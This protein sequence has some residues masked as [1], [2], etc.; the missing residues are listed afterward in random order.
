MSCAL[1]ATDGNVRE[2]LRLHLREEIELLFEPA[3]VRAGW[4][5]PPVDFT[6]ARTIERGHGRIEERSVTSSMLADDSDWP[7]L[8]HVFKLEYGS[9]DSV[10]GKETTAVRSG[11]T[12][13]PVTV[14]DAKGLLVSTREHWGI[15]TGLHRQRD[16]SLG[17]DGMH[18]RTGQAPHGLATLNTVVLSL[19][20]HQ[21]ITNGTEPQRAMASHLDRFLHQITT[22]QR[23]EAMA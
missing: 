16:G 1:S 8:A 18:T 9:K 11:V 5:V 6:T 12:R 17:E 23:V 20:G 22:S 4:S 2:V 19:M 15:E 21:G 10:T 14:R 13:T 3:S 7:Y